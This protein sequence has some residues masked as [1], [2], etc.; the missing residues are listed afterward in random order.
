V[1][2]WLEK[3]ECKNVDPEIFFPE[4]GESLKPARKYCDIC[5]V[6]EECLEYAVVNFIVEGVWGGT[7]GR[8]RRALKKQRRMVKDDGAYT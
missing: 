2:E 6:R 5:M 1:N 4:Q 8:Q 7:S 3:A